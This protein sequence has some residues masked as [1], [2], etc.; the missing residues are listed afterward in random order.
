L[1]DR[2]GYSL[3]GWHGHHDPASNLEFKT[4][5]TTHPIGYLSTHFSLHC[6]GHGIADYVDDKS[7]SSI[8]RTAIQVRP[9]DLFLVQTWIVIVSGNDV[10]LVARYYDISGRFLKEATIADRGAISRSWNFV[11]ALAAAPPTAAYLGLG[12]SVNNGTAE[13]TDFCVTRAS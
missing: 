7:L 6:N 8:Q 3:A 1:Y 4:T 10:R 13:W 12:V 11:Q 9:G 2:Y 5:S